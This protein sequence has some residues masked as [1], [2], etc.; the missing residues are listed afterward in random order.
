VIRQVS[1]TTNADGTFDA[2]S[3][4]DISGAAGVLSCIFQETGNVPFKAVLF[5]NFDS[6]AATAYRID[7][8]TPY[9]AQAIT[10]VVVAYIY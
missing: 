8:G 7:D 5:P 4:T 6:I 3:A 1:V 10:G 2:L 9:G